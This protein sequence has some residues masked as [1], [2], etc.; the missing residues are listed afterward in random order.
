MEVFVVKSSSNYS[1]L[2]AGPCVLGKMQ[3][4]ILG[5]HGW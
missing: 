1:R 2:Y 4:K 3:E 5:C